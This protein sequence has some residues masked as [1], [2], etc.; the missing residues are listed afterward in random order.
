MNGRFE[1]MK[2]KKKGEMKND[3]KGASSRAYRHAHI[4]NEE[5]CANLLDESTKKCYYSIMDTIIEINQKIAKNI[6][7]Y[8]KAA[9]LTQAELAEKINYSDKS[10]SK[11]ESGNGIPDVY[12]LMQMARLFGVTLN[13]LV[14]EETLPVQKPEK[15]AISKG[16][17]AL[18]MLL[19]S[20]IVW[21][22]ATLVFIVL[23]L[24]LPGGGAWWVSF[25]YAVVAN[26]IVTLVYGCIWK[27]RIIRAISISLIVW[28]SLT[29]LY[30]TA[31]MIFFY[32]DMES[33]ALW[34]IF[35]L[36]IPLQ[37]M[38]IFWESFRTLLRKQ[39][40]KPQE[41]VVENANVNVKSN[42][43]EK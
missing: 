5:K 31:Y 33:G 38:E 37:C 6:M 25:V 42:G 36:G 18:I 26:A 13:D 34:L 12:T 4:N 14:G 43:E 27:H 16:M 22:V 19:S 2:S 39:K 35:L 21:L 3:E 1:W 23:Q 9:G 17:Q 30:L 32:N 28:V 29:A 20:G 24:L 41:D 10:V 40:K 8:R 15:R 11:W 7:T